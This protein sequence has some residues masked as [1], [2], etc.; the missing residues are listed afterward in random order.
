MSIIKPL[1]S[2]S[3]NI[4]ETHLL[5]ITSCTNLFSI[6]Q[7]IRNTMMH[8]HFIQSLIIH[9]IMIYAAIQMPTNH[10]VPITIACQ[11]YHISCI[12][13]IQ[14]LTFIVPMHSYFDLPFCQC[15]YQVGIRFFRPTHRSY[16][17]TGRKL[18]A[19]RFL[20]SP[21]CTY[22]VNKYNIIR[23]SDS[24]SIR[25]RW[26]VH[27]SHNIRLALFWCFGWKLI[28]LLSTFII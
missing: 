7:S 22:F 12:R 26:K 24:Y 25:I 18:V 5:I 23:L 28:F 15:K 21:F 17:W 20:I 9:I 2:I 13:W 4:I 19:N 1:Q 27:C 16:W 3:L 6:S 14:L 10:F 8:F 11:T